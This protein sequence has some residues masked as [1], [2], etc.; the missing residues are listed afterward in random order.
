MVV[1][2]VETH[3]LIGL[4]CFI[5]GFIAS[6]YYYSS[7]VRASMLGQII[8][9]SLIRDNVT[10]LASFSSSLHNLVTEMKKRVDGLN[11]QMHITR[12]MEKL[13]EIDMFG[14]TAISEKTEAFQE[15]ENDTGNTDLG[16]DES[17]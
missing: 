6:R 9:Y 14:I 12:N 16:Q 1:R 13:Y 11:S 5:I 10:E 2:V 8:D 4:I 3:L 17:A 15:T 7:V